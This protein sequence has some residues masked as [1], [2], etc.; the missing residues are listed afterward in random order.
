[1]SVAHSYANALY[2]FVKETLPKGELDARADEIQD[3][4]DHLINV[5]NVSR[6]ARIALEGPLTNTREKVS[7]V[8]KIAEKIQAS[9]PLQRFLILLATKGRLGILSEIRDEFSSVRLTARGGLRG[10]VVSA[11]PMTNEDLAGLARSFTKKLGKPVAFIANTDASLLAGV[12]VTVSGVT[13][14]GTLRA[15]LD[16]LRNRLAL[17]GAVN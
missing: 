1:M 16:Q 12:K 9:Q 13:Y 8:T 11:E 17:S 10:H 5:M 2:Q 3:Q 14:D 7:L 6:E 15:Q 4:M